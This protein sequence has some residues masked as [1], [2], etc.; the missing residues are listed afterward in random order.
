MVSILSILNISFFPRVV[1]QGETPSQKNLILLIGLE[2]S[3]LK[4]NCLQYREQ[5][6]HAFVTIRAQVKHLRV[7]SAAII[8]C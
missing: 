6:F 1:K 5:S 8:C 3:E 7:S 2:N 4:K